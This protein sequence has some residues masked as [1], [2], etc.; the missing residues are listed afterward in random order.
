VSDVLELISQAV[1]A[2]VVV[3]VTAAVAFV[4]A[5]LPEWRSQHP[6]KPKQP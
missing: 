5:A 2:G 4:L 3:L 1:S 6:R